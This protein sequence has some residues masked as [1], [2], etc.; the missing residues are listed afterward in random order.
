MRVRLMEW[1]IDKC[2][3]IVIHTLRNF[4]LRHKVLQDAISL[5]CSVFAARI[6][7]DYK[8]GWPDFSR[9]SV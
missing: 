9:A 1:Q 6:F 7:K 4:V 2:L 3:L 5:A 8:A